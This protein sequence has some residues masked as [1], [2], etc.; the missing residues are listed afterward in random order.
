MNAISNLKVEL[1][2]AEHRLL[3]ELRT[4]FAKG[5]FAA[6]F[7]YSLITTSPAAILGLSNGEGCI[8]HTGAADLIAIRD[9]RTTPAATLCGITFADIELVIVAGRIQVACAELYGR[10]PESLR[11]GLQPL[12]VAGPARR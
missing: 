9:R 6:E 1:H 4:L 3:D 2:E 12:D 5:L 10:L 7:L 11:D 8:Q